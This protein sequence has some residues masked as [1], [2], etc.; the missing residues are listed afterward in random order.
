[1]IS[2]PLIVA[3]SAVLLL[4]PAVRAEEPVRLGAWQ[5]TV[6]ELGTPA[7]VAVLPDGVVAVVETDRDRVSLLTAEGS[8]LIDGAGSKT[9]A[10][11]A[12]AG[13]AAA[14]DG[15][16]VVSDTGNHRIVIFD[17]DGTP[18]R[19]FGG[20]GVGDGE[21]LEPR[22]IVATADRIVVA[23]RGNDR[24]QVFDRDGV[25]R[26]TIGGSGT[27]PGRFRR[28]LDVALDEA[29]RIYVADAGN[30]RI[31]V[32]DAAGRLERTWGEWGAFPGLL[33]E[34]ASIAVVGPRV[35]V[36]DRRNHRVQTFDRLGALVGSWGVHAI[37]PH[38]HEGALHYPDSI[39]IAPEAGIAVVG[40]S[41][42]DRLQIVQLCAPGEPDPPAP[43]AW[44]SDGKQV[45][46]GRRLATDDLLLAI[47]EPEAQRVHLFEMSRTI[48]IVIGDFGERGE[49]YGLLV[50]SEAVALDAAARAL[51]LSDEGKGRL[52]RFAF[53]WEPDEPRAF[54]QNRFRLSRSW[55]LARIDATG[56]DGAFMPVALRRDPRGGLWA[57]D[58]RNVRVVRLD[59]ALAPSIAFGTWG[60]GVGDLRA[61]TDLAVAPEGDRILV[62]D[63]HR[64][65]ILVFDRAGAVVGTIGGPEPERGGMLR[66]FGVVA[67][68]DGTTWVTD[69]GA[70][71]VLHF[72]A[73]GRLIRAFGGRGVEHGQFW[74]PSGI[75]E[76]HEGRIIV[77]DWG[78]HRAQIFSPEG[79]WLVTFGTGRA[80][81]PRR[82]AGA[83]PTTEPKP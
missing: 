37:L 71:R 40:E 74:K 1:M 75:V 45:H 60:D 82:D 53:D 36:V 27:E 34:P 21:L 56:D 39:T 55:D 25:H 57:L 7:D 78:N 30:D 73:D 32:F 47:P 50:R 76:D 23:D 6:A 41:F 22:G 65:R 44:R 9:G 81:T 59:E 3:L 14:P 35:L 13:L 19:A 83:L 54:R 51:W 42:E 16:I 26:L 11:L 8:R 10:L 18:I 46:F 29:G 80:Y 58:A 62:A 52:Q 79:E 28:P 63:A 24:V 61:P 12:P 72:D 70:D 69:A 2:R 43:P 15:T 33:D 64:R 38:E 49:G 20:R 77:I 5:R 48:P 17:A 4:P 67:A 31:Q 66:P 68:R